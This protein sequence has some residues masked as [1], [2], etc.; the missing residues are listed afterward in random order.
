VNGLRCIRDGNERTSILN[1][2]KV[3]LGIDKG[4]TN[5]DMIAT[6]TCNTVRDLWKRVKR[7]GHKL[8]TNVFLSPDLFQNL[9]MKKTSSCGTVRPN[10]VGLPQG[11]FYVQQGKP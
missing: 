4:C 10:H 2:M 11:N 3:H 5:Q 6:H 9:A 1:D 7:V 8:H